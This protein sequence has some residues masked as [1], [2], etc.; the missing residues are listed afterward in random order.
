M[1]FPSAG[2]KQIR[3]WTIVCFRLSGLLKRPFFLLHIEAVYFKIG[4]IGDWK[5]R[6][7][8]PSYY[9]RRKGI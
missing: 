9:Q 3:A 5:G 6:F 2:R 8:G 7:S 4:Y 1:S